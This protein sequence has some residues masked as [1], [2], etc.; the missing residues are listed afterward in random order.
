MVEAIDDADLNTWGFPRASFFEP[1]E[2][3]AR[4][5]GKPLPHPP[6]LD[7]YRL[8]RKLLVVLRRNIQH[9]AFGRLVRRTR[10]LCDVLLRG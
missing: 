7:R 9:N 5:G 10:T 1:V 8:Q 2:R 4:A 3:A 6:L